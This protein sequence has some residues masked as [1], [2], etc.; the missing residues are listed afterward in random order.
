MFHIL[1][2]KSGC[3]E[4]YI[5]LTHIYHKHASSI[6]Y[7]SDSTTPLVVFSVTYTIGE[8]SKPDA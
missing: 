7:N 4:K 2:V 3:W 8:R 6:D 1:Q 5:Q